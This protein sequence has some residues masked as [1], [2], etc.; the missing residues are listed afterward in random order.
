MR[1]SEESIIEALA[2]AE[3][4]D[5]RLQLDDVNGIKLLNDAY[6]ANPNSMRAALETVAALP[7]TG[8]RIAVL[9]EMR[10]LGKSSDRYHREIGEFAATCKLDML[11]CVG[12]QGAL[13]AEAAHKAGMPAK[14]VSTFADAPS[15]APMVRKWAKKNDLV[16]L[17]ASR[18][19]RLEFIAQALHAETAQPAAARVRKAAG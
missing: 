2:T 15:A 6:N 14:V 17:K 12:P 19:I 1:V 11:V 10:E 9:G 8:R 3:G 4:P 18:G 5:M 7:T 16:L 13:I